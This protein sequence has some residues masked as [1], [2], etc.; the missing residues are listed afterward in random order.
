MNRFNSNAF[1]D[2]IVEIETNNLIYNEKFNLTKIRHN[3]IKN[4]NISNI[5]NR[6][7][8][9]CFYKNSDIFLSE[10]SYDSRLHLIKYVV[11]EI[12]IIQSYYIVFRFMN[13]LIVIMLS[14]CIHAKSK[15]PTEWH[16]TI[17]IT[18]FRNNYLKTFHNDR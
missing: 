7:D 8:R 3:I 17:F 6:L 13:K 9:N 15:I 16:Q 1:M 4:N 5:V 11:N 12:Y 14:K 2:F 10:K 18:L